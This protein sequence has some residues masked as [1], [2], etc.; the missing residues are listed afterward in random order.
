MTVYDIALVGLGIRGLGFV[1]ANPELRDFRV[2]IVSDT[3]MG[4]GAFGDLA[5][6]SNSVGSDFFN[7]IDEEGPYGSILGLP[8]VRDLREIESCFELRRLGRALSDA[9]DLIVESAP[10][11]WLIESGRVTTIER[12]QGGA[13]LRLDSGQQLRAR[14]VV[15][16]SGVAE[17]PDATLQNQTSEFWLSSSLLRMSDQTDAADLFPGATTFAVAGTSHSAFSAANKLMQMGVG[18][19]AITLLGRSGVRLHYDSLADYTNGTHSHIE[20]VPDETLDVCSHTGQVFRYHGL[21]HSS[22]ELFLSVLADQVPLKIEVL[23]D[24]ADRHHVMRGADVLVQACGYTSRIPAIYDD[25]VVDLSTIVQRD[26]DGHLLNRYGDRVPGIFVMGCDPYPYG[27][28]DADPTTQYARRGAAV[29]S[30]MV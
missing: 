17:V 10:E 7:W 16:A 8:A 15:L 22:R 6:Q 20:M 25:G 4:P 23:P 3:P 24:E 2:A 13:L 19:E 26:V 27:N 28:V 12:A 30:E 9:A 29:L 5:C 21:R 1:T 11:S 14:T 18:A